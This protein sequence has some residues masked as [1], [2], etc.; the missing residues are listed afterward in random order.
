M[1]QLCSQIKRAIEL[2]LMGDIEDEVLQNT[3]VHSVEPAPGNRLVV[4]L[5]VHP[6]GSKM[7]KEEVLRRL[8]QHRG[9]IVSEVSRAVTRR[10]LPELTFWLIK[11]GGLAE[12]EEPT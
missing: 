11:E 4:T 1:R 9:T 6:P 8:E 3:S 12:P 7:A 10:A 5:T 2:T